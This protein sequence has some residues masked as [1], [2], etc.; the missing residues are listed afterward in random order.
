MATR[1]DIRDA[2]YSQL[3]SVAGTYDVTDTNGNVV[4]TIT[5]DAANIKLR[6]PADEDV[7]HIVYHD[8]YTRLG[9]N[10]VGRGPHD[11]ELN[12][13]GSV[14]AALY[15]EYVEAQFIIDLRV[16]GDVAEQ[17]KEPVYEQLRSTFAKYERGG[18]RP[19]DFHSDATRIRVMEASTADTGD[20]ED[21][22]RGDQL[23]V[24]V[25]FRRIYRLD[26]A[27]IDSVETAMD[28]D[29]DGTTEDTYTTT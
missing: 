9:Y 23:E 3:S 7:P 17:R 27:N 22:I 1:G 14:S 5:L 2:F 26:E 19:S 28:A 13:D 18:W 25:E 10:L 4:D 16:G 15:H 12:Q 20:V 29:N 6:H 11:Y 21:V 8:N 24:R